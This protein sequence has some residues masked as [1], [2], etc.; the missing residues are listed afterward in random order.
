MLSLPESW[1]HKEEY[2]IFIF[3]EYVLK[4]NEQISPSAS[5]SLDSHSLSPELN[6]N[7]GRS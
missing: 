2:R 7:Q 4:W 5:Q 1:C 3:S 6:V